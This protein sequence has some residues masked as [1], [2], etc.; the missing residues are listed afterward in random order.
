MGGNRAHGGA[1]EAVIHMLDKIG[2]VSNI[3]SFIAKVKDKNS[4]VR[5]MGLWASRV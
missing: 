5:L 3:D 4:G 1:N 2:D